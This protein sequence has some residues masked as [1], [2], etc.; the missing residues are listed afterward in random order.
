[1]VVGYASGVIRGLVKVE[2]ELPKGAQI[3][4]SAKRGDVGDDDDDDDD[5]SDHSDSLADGQS[6][7]ADSS[8]RF[9]FEK[10]LPGDYRVTARAFAKLPTGPILGDAKQSVTVAASGESFVTILLDLRGKSKDR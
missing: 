5:D 8:G 4:V 10:L 1:M 6:T 7:V 2:G 3:L 9:S